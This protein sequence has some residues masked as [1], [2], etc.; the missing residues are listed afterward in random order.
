MLPF[1]ENI[2][3]LKNF[4][5]KSIKNLGTYDKF[6]LKNFNEVKHDFVH[7]LLTLYGFLLFVISLTNLP[8]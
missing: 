2:K 7:L 3:N 8:I 4:K 6:I 1:F 5:K